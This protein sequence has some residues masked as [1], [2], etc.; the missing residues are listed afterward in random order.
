[1]QSYHST[2]HPSTNVSNRLLHTSS[3]VSGG[4]YSITEE[5]A[6]TVSEPTRFDSQFIDCM[7]MYADLATVSRYFDVHQEWFRRCAHPMQAELIDR[8]SYALIIGRYGSFGYEVEPKIG[9]NLLP[10]DHGIYRIETVPVPGN[11]PAGYDVDFRAAMELVEIPISERQGIAAWAAPLPDK[12]TR[13]Q[14]QLDL[15]VLIQF[16]RFIH[17]LPKSLIQSTGDRVL[18]QV[19][20][21]VSGRLTRKVLEDFHQTHGLP[22]PKR[23][24]PRIFRK[25]EHEL[26]LQ[27]PSKPNE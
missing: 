17:A 20:R 12:I 19:V 9:L 2:E 5:S 7:E 16:P 3:M 4:D 1:M 14:W 18:Q 26:D 15:T 22:I 6:Q 10:Q 11:V 24:K 13:V 25:H 21:Q 23:A 8:N 27:P